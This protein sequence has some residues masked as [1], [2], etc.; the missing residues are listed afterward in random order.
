MR[1]NARETDIVGRWGGEEFLVICPETTLLVVTALAERYRIEMERSDFGAVG[2]VTSSFGVTATQE[3]DDIHLLVRRADEAL[4]R[5]KE[6]GRN[7]VESD[8]SRALH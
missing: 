1:R 7:R 6:S 4:Y 2:Q 8:Q 5:A 3:G